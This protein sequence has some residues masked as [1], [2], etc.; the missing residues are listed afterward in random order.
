MIKVFNYIPEVDAFLP[1]P[2]FSEIARKLGLCEWTDVVF[3]C[4]LF[5][6]D[7]D[8]GEHIFDNWDEREERESKCQSLGIESSQLLVVDPERFQ[9]GWDGPCHSKKIRK[10]FWTDVL[11]SLT[12]S[13]EFLFEEARRTTQKH[14]KNA[15][16]FGNLTPEQLELNIQ[17]VREKYESEQEANTSR[18]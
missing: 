10:L 3:I 15:R 17:E 11:K 2:E 12:L 6:L 13:L 1:T 18:L 16:P 7:N 5:A 14:K 9:N 8:Y 4:R